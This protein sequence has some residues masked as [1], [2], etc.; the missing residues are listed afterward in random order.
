MDMDT[1]HAILTDEGGIPTPTTANTTSSTTSHHKGVNTLRKMMQQWSAEKSDAIMYFFNNVN[2]QRLPYKERIPLTEIMVMAP[3]HP[4]NYY[5]AKV[6]MKKAVWDDEI[7]ITAIG[8]TTKVPS[9][10]DGMQYVSSAW[11]QVQTGDVWRIAPNE[12]NFTVHFLD[13]DDI[14]PPS[15]TSPSTTPWKT[16]LDAFKYS[17]LENKPTDDSVNNMMRS[18]AAQQQYI[19]G[20]GFSCMGFTL[21]LYTGKTSQ[22]LIVNK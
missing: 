12:G 5:S 21:D 10:R 20:V 2:K 1:L 13:A 4:V 3:H 7:P 15:L 18:F 9:L 6:L 17:N 14:L 8:R 11:R 22:K 16:I 19:P